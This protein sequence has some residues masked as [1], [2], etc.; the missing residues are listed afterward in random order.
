MTAIYR[1]YSSSNRKY[2]VCQYTCYI[3]HISLS[4]EGV[5]IDFAL[6]QACVIRENSKI[7]TTMKQPNQ[8]L[9][10]CNLTSYRRLLLYSISFRNP[11]LMNFSITFQRDELLKNASLNK[12]TITNK[13]WITEK[14]Y[15]WVPC[16]DKMAH[17]LA[18]SDS[19]FTTTVSTSSGN[20]HKKYCEQRIETIWWVLEVTEG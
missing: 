7:I 16:I 8:T 18:F 9:R 14:Q 2:R 19:A 20:L 13:K 11:S 10:N 17:N 12:K 1:L 15:T 5:K 4:I 6:P 3:K